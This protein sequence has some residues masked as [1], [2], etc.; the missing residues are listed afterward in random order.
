MVRSEHYYTI[1]RST[2]RSKPVT[3]VC[4]HA[5]RSGGDTDDDDDG[6]SDCKEKPRDALIC[7]ILSHY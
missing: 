5:C 1:R 4:M 7:H 6:N 3:P 2:P